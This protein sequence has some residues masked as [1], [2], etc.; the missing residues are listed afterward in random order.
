MRYNNEW[1]W[2]VVVGG[3][4]TQTELWPLSYK[5]DLLVVSIVYILIYLC[6]TRIVWNVS[7]K[8]QGKPF[9]CTIS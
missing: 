5:P 8:I 6:A 1:E 2:R 9:M 4:E 7:L 3:G